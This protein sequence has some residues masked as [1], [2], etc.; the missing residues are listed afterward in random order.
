MFAGEF[1]DK[2]IISKGVRTDIESYKANAPHVRALK[3]AIK[4]GY[5]PA[6]NVIQFVYGN[7]DVVPII[8]GKDMDIVYDYKKYWKV[9]VKDPVDRIVNAVYRRQATLISFL[10]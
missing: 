3:M 8:P 7:G 1:N 10:G 9:Y 2:L 6:D 4:E 5:T